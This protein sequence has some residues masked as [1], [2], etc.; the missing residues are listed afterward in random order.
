MYLS[1]RGRINVERDGR[2]IMV[3]DISTKK[4]RSLA[5]VPALPELV[6][7][8]HGARAVTV[9][10]G[11]TVFRSPRGRDSIGALLL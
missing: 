3:A 2:E 10:L 7:Q 1:S 8:V 5:R 9:E 11:T 6:Q 4:G